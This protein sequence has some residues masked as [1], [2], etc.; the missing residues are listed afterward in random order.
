MFVL[1]VRTP[2]LCVTLTSSKLQSAV[3]F[4]KFHSVML[5]STDADANTLLEQE[6]LFYQ[7]GG[8]RLD[9]N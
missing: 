1:S 9:L 3:N 6:S 7:H 8:N 5:Q 4:E 2:G